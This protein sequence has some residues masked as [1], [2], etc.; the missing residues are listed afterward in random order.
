MREP[1]FKNKPGKPQKGAIMTA[2]EKKIRHD[3]DIEL[4]II[5]AGRTEIEE[6]AQKML[7]CSPDS[8]QLLFSH[9]E[10]EDIHNRQ[11]P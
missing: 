10:T 11:I 8:Y 4:P 9:Q 1:A 6:A 5:A 3:S 7:G 2:P